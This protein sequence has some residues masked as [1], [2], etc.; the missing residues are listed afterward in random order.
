MFI[1][2]IDD[3]IPELTE[4]LVSS[5]GV[6]EG[7]SQIL[8]NDSLQ[9]LMTASSDGATEG[10]DDAMRVD[11]VFNYERQGDCLSQNSQILNNL[12]GPHLNWISSKIYV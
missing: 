8:D 3:N 4:E 11:F 2:A 12:D 5:V 7:S 6:I 1:D 10:T 9:P